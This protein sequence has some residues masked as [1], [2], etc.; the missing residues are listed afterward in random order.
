MTE[1]RPARRP[2]ALNL[3]LGALFV[4]GGLF[5]LVKLYGLKAAVKEGRS[6]AEGA[7]NPPSKP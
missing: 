4:A 7:F 3:A 5:L 2:G 6:A 1:P